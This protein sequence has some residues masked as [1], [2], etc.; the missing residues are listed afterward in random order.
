MCRFNSFSPGQKAIH[1][2]IPWRGAEISFFPQPL[3]HF[4]DGISHTHE[5][6]YVIKNPARN[7]KFLF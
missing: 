2:G 7:L 1:V 6:A 5:I 4:A 3:R